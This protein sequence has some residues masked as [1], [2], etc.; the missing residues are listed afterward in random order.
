MKTFVS[1]CFILLV[2]LSSS[3]YLPIKF[4]SCYPVGPNDVWLAKSVEVIQDPTLNDVITISAKGFVN[5][6]GYYVD[7][8]EILAN[9]TVGDYHWNDT[10]P[11]FNRIVGYGKYLSLNYT[12]AI[13]KL[14]EN[15]VNVTMQALGPK[16][17]VL[18]CVDIV[19]TNRTSI[20]N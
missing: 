19:L 15:T 18:G 3:R 6:L 11:Y 10:I 9:G 8:Q 13:P 4:E 16:G 7:F 14:N 17:N 20:W 2:T 1:L 5:N 12:T